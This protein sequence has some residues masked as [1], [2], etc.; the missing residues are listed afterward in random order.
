MKPIIK[1]IRHLARDQNDAKLSGI[2]GSLWNTVYISTDPTAN[3]AGD[4][5]VYSV[6]E[7]VPAVQEP[8]HKFAIKQRKSRYESA[9]I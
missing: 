4:L 2:H 5:I 3:P 8:S 7:E 6:G 9:H 1:V